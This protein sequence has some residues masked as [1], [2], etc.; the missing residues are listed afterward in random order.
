MNSQIC[1][2]GRIQ[3]KLQDPSSI[4]PG[5]HLLIDATNQILAILTST[6]FDLTCLETRF[7]IIC[8]NVQE[9][10]EN[11]KLIQVTHIFDNCTKQDKQDKQ[12]KQNKE[13]KE[14]KHDCSCCSNKTKKDTCKKKDKCK[15][16][17]CCKTIPLCDIPDFTNYNP[18]QQLIFRPIQRPTFQPIV[19]P[20]F[21]PIVLPP[22]EP[23]P[24]PNCF[25]PKC[26]HKCCKK[27]CKK[28]CPLSIESVDSPLST[29]VCLVCSRPV[30]KGWVLCCKCISKFQTN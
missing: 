18:I 23:I 11:V 5:T 24:N 10:I 27:D 1:L 28:D 22:A 13:V 26:C 15:K 7:V 30:T 20:A 8:G 14:V 12:N 2:S 29:F 21:E 16:K 9:I 6:V 3:R 19:Q 25:P 17:K 4:Q